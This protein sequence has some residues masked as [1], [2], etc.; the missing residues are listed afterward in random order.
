MKRYTRKL[1]KKHKQ[2]IKTARKT[3]KR[4]GRRTNKKCEDF[5]KNDFLPNRRLISQK[6]ARDNNEV[7]IERTPKEHKFAFKTCKNVYCNKGCKN[8]FTDT[9]FYKDISNDFNNNYNNYQINKLKEKG[10]LSGCRIDEKYVD[11]YL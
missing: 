5:C 6:R 7:Y 1:H 11:N 8:K 2:F 3:N 4:G 9:G 10:A